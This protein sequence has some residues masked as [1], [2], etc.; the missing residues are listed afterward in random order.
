MNPDRPASPGQA[1]TPTT[2]WEDVDVP[3]ALGDPLPIWE[4]VDVPS[5]LNDPPAP[6]GWRDCDDVPRALEILDADEAEG[7]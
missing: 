5:A 6:V 2:T 4:D 3:S 1:E 7:S